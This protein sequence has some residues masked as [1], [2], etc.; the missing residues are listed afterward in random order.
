MPGTLVGAGAF[1]LA[2][3]LVAV[4]APWLAPGIPSG[5]RCGPA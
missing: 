4:A 3:A 1:V 5:G 2:L